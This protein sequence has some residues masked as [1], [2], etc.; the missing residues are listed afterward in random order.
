MKV[1]F[2]FADCCCSSVSRLINMIYILIRHYMLDDWKL[3]SN[4]G[5]TD[6]Q[7]ISIWSR[8]IIRG[9]FIIFP[10]RIIL[11]LIIIY[12]LYTI[13]WVSMTRIEVFSSWIPLNFNVLILNQF[14]NSPCKLN[15]TIPWSVLC[16]TG[17]HSLFLEELIK[18]IHFYF[19]DDH[20]LLLF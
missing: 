7:I 20:I 5:M 4:W 6:V 2:S 19:L 3:I 9:W 10:W 11:S 15:V 16:I 8:K 18:F 17:I 14:S 12:S 13:R 1:L